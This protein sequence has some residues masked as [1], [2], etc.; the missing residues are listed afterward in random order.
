MNPEIETYQDQLLSVRQDA[1]GLMSGLSDAQFNWRP[2]PGRWSMAEC[3]DHLNVSAAK[4]FIPR[5]DGAIATGRAQHL[6][7]AGPFVHPMFQRLFLRISEPPP[8]IRFKAPRLV[9]PAADRPVDVVRR[10]FMEWQDR[11]G[12]RLLQADGLD[13]CRARHPSALRLWRWSLG[14]FFSVMLAHERRHIWQARQVRTD[15]RFPTP[16]DAP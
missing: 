9:Q 11:L 3:F 8:R 6:E 13:L 7:G 5:I 12:E 2:D 4:L 1:G 14:T 16:A 10:E 15:P